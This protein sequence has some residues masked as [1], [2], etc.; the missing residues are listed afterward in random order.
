MRFIGK[1]EDERQ[2]VEMI[3]RLPV[4]KQLLIC[5]RNWKHWRLACQYN[6]IE[7]ALMDAGFKKEA[8]LV[9]EQAVYHWHCVYEWPWLAG[10]AKVDDDNEIEHCNTFSPDVPPMKANHKYAQP[11]SF[12]VLDLNLALADIHARLC[13]LE[14]EVK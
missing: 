9:H 8:Y 12:D 14:G 4:W 3:D 7:A 11:E 6:R 2:M 10:S 1:S 13:R 5:F